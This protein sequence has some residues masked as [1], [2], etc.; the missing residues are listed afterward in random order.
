MQSP[1]GAQAAHAQAQA[2]ATFAQ[3][4]APHPYTPMDLRRS[5]LPAH[6]VPNAA[7]NLSYLMSPYSVLQQGSTV[8]NSAVGSSALPSAPWL[9]MPVADPSLWIQD[10]S[11]AAIGSTTPSSAPGGASGNVVDSKRGS[12]SSEW[13]ARSSG[14][15]TTAGVSTATP[16]DTP[17]SSFGNVPATSILSPTSTDSA[18]SPASATTAAPPSPSVVKAEHHTSAAPSSESTRPLSPPRSASGFALAPPGSFGP[19]DPDLFQNFL[20]EG[21]HPSLFQQQGA[22]F[23]QPHTHASGNLQP[24]SMHHL[25][26]LRGMGMGGSLSGIPGLGAPS[27]LA[28]GNSTGVP[29]NGRD[30]SASRG[31]LNYNFRSFDARAAEE[32][33]FFNNAATFHFAQPHNQPHTA[34]YHGSSA[35]AAFSAHSH[36]VNHPNAASM[37]AAHSS[38]LLPHP[39]LPPHTQ[40]PHAHLD[41]GALLGEMAFLASGSP[42][43]LLP[44]DGRAKRSRSSQMPAPA[45]SEDSG[46]PYGSPEGG[47]IEGGER[48]FRCDVDGCHKTFKRSGHLKRHRLVHL[49]PNQRERYRCWKQTCNKHYSTKYDLAAHMRQAHGGVEL[50]RCTVRNCARRFVRPESLE[51]HLKTFDHSKD[52]GAGPEQ[53]DDEDYEELSAYLQSAPAGSPSRAAAEEPYRHLLNA[54][55]ASSPSSMAPPPPKRLAPL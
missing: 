36:L 2:S 5:I 25:D 7:A 17:T 4:Q 39:M 46:S 43:A 54:A 47:A 8:A 49:P 23:A 42:G 38:A 1:L 21:T 3:P 37:S 6:G 13:S 31:K 20:P 35:A 55:E 19:F 9:G 40:L 15:A 27:P 24:Y 10:R 29:L 18:A 26:M 22:Q 51:K 30:F 14:S 45:G 53:I 52:H 50:L 44:S 11:R 12:F 41:N 28:S 32:E 16:V 48:K 33:A 34:H